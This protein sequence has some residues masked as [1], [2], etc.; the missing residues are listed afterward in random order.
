MKLVIICGPPASGKMTVGQELKKIT[1]YKL[2]FNHMSL[3]LVNQFFD[4]GTSNFK[5]LDKKIRF[6]IFEEVAKSEIPGLIFTLVWAFNEK[7]DEEYINMIIDIFKNRNPKVCLVELDCELEERLK[8]NR[9][10]NRLSHKPS[11]RDVNI[12]DKLLL[13]EDKLYRM[14][15]LDGEF[16]EEKIMKIENTRKTAKEVAEMIIEHYELK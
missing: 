14:N 2:F 3:E 15:S 5:N 9:T 13:S 16:P 10:D 1:G 7:E 11:K 6:D 4:F 12:S 8:R